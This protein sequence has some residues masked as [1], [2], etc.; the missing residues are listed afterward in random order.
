MTSKYTYQIEPQ[1]SRI[2]RDSELR[3]LA[4]QRE[5]IVVF[6]VG[7]PFSG[8][9]SVAKI[10]ADMAGGVLISARSGANLFAE[11]ADASLRVRGRYTPPVVIVDGA[12]KHSHIRPA[13]EF[14]RPRPTVVVATVPNEEYLWM[15]AKRVSAKWRDAADENETRALEE[16]RTLVNERRRHIDELRKVV[17][18]TGNTAQDVNTSENLDE[19]V[20]EVRRHLGYLERSGR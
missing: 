20:D 1:L 11:I 8:K 15:R 19:C 16:F 10:L 5:T 6:V 17:F 18:P 14:F 13:F 4:V 3:V 12:S 7:L 2:Y 9:T